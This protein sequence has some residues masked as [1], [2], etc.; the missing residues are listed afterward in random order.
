MHFEITGPIIMM[1]CAWC[2]ISIVGQM[3]CQSWC[4]VHDV[5]SLLVTGLSIMMSCVWCHISIVGQ[6]QLD[7]QSWCHVCDV[8]SLLL[9]RI[10]WPANHDVMCMM[11]HLYCWAD[12]NWGLK[13]PWVCATLAHI[14]SKV[15]DTLSLSRYITLSC[16][17]SRFCEVTNEFKYLIRLRTWVFYF[18]TFAHS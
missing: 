16:F 10:N 14:V 4:H 18:L 6:D 2:H 13:L 17:C 9:G 12:L 1:S 15:Q 3:D 5:T 11:P 7:C 8:T